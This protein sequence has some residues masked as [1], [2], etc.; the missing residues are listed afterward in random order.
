MAASKVC[1]KSCCK[2]A[3]SNRMCQVLFV[4]KHENMV[5]YRP[6]IARLIQGS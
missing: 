5:A 3:L 4:S 1:L 6:A 2:S